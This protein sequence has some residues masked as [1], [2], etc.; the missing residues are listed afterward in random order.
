MVKLPDVVSA[1][2]EVATPI[3]NRSPSCPFGQRGSVLLPIRYITAQREDLDRRI[4]TAAR[5]I[6]DEVLCATASSAN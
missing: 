2:A 4:G 1:P 6:G 3:V 5:G